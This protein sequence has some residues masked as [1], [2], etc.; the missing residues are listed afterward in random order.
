MPRKNRPMIEKTH[1]DVV[2]KDQARGQIAADDFAEKA[3][4]IKQDLS[5]DL[6]RIGTCA[7]SADKCAR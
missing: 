3:G 4:W 1:R 5:L 6:F 2:F 7:D